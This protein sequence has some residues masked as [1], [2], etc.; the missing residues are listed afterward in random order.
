VSE[1]EELYDEDYVSEPARDEVAEPASSTGGEARPEPVYGSLEQFLAEYLLP[2]YRRAVSGTSTT[3][4]AQ[5]WRHSEA[6]IRLDGLWRSWEYLR[7][8]AA[9][10]MSVW[11]RDHADP[12]M[13]VLLSADGPFKGCTPDQH[14]TRPLK[15]LPL[16]PVPEGT[17]DPTAAAGGLLSDR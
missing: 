5:W 4:C 2:V 15:A 14:A 16:A 10:G 3:W 7:L 17:P 1:F 6:W 8:D 9:T 12:H 11:L 13:A